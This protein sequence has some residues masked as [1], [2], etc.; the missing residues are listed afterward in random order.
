MLARRG[1]RRARR[2][3]PRARRVRRSGGRQVAPDR[4]ARRGGR[5]G[6]GRLQARW[7]RARTLRSARSGGSSTRATRSSFATGRNSGPC[8]LGPELAG[9]PAEAAGT[10]G[11]E[12][13]RRLF[14]AAA[15]ALVLYAARAPV[16]L[17]V[18]DVQ[19]SDLAS[20]E[21]AYHLALVTHAVP[22]ALAL[23]V[24]EDELDEQ[25]AR[26]VT[27]LVRLPARGGAAAGAAIA[28]RRGGG[29]RPRAAARGA[30]VDARAAARDRDRGGR[31]PALPARAR[32][33]RWRGVDAGRG[34]A[35]LARRERSDPAARAA[36]GGAERPARGFDPGGVRRRPR[37]ARRRLLGRCG[38]GG[39]A[40]RDRRGIRRAARPA[41]ARP[42][43][44]ARAGAARRPRRRS[45][46]RAAAAAPR[47]AALS[48]SAA[49]P[50][51]GL[52][53]SCTARLGGRRACRGGALERAG[54]GAAFAR[55][56]FADAA[57]LYQRA[58]AAS[59][60]AE[61]ALLDKE[62]LALERAG[63]PAAALPLLARCLAAY[64]DRTPLVRVRCCCASRGPSSAPLAR[65]K[66]RA[67][68]IGRA[69]YS[70]APSRRPRTTPSTCSGLGW[71]QPRRTPTRRWRRWPR[72]SRTAST[73]TASG[74][75]GRT[76]PPASRRSSAA[77]STAGGPA[78][79]A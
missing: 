15:E 79:R 69:R 29:A 2:G 40:G 16:E 56:A 70:T 45:A 18:E 1:A 31:Q 74:R 43:L 37:G 35:D 26:I 52:H 7:T 21:L 59:Q 38:G 61:T 25:R 65:A 41:V 10:E 71:P 63:R 34:A 14:D 11:S 50:R 12:R 78:T 66:R 42:A 30:R 53:P 4:G 48:R 47:D 44:L 51:P 28:G 27:R 76:R 54:R 60:T 22:L 49:A 32:P 19:W 9:E 64:A 23:T 20:L 36:G 13:K 39:L 5:D 67:R 77:T 46:R 8:W 62:A 24:R 73:A 55:S 3:L 68:S 17:I 72:R 33:P 6:A 57:D 58:T 75:C